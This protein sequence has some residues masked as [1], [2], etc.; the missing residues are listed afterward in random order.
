MEN[1]P[2]SDNYWQVTQAHGR[3]SK[4]ELSSLTVH[5]FSLPDFLTFN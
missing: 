5:H 2:H 3:F 4:F 1:V